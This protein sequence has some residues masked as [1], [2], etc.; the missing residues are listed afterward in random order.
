[1]ALS[2]GHQGFRLGLGATPVK[3]VSLGSVTVWSAGIAVSDDF[4]R[5]DGGLGTAYTALGDA[6]VIAAGRV[7]AD[8]PG[9]QQTV[10]YAAR[11]NT[12]LTTDTQEIVFTPTAPTGAA[13]LGLGGG[14]FLRGTASGDRIEALVTDTQAV[15]ITR[16]GGT[17]TSRESALILTP[18]TVRFTAVGNTYSIYVNSAPEPSVT[19]TDH[20]A[21]IAIGPG[22]RHIGVVVIGQSGLNVLRGYAI[23]DYTARDVL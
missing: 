21:T 8:T 11:H 15:I 23:D 18:R 7:Q 5:P 17:T 19:W 13:N 10:V 16:I 6:P 1:M 14:C 12:A 2:I 9:F 3:A 22:N 20:A 4:A